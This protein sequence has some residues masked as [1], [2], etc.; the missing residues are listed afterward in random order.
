MKHSS[1]SHVREND[2]GALWLALADIAG[3]SFKQSGAADLSS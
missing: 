3:R 2:P 1:I